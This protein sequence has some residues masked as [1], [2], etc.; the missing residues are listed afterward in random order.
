MTNLCY[1]N[2]WKDWS[3]VHHLQYKGRSIRSHIHI[4]YARI[5]IEIH[6]N[7]PSLAN[8]VRRSPILGPQPTQV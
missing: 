8:A 4:G 5:D 6:S 2:E 7:A 1:V 3:S